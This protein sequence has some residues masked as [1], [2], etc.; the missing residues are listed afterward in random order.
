MHRVF[1]FSAGPAMLPLEVLEASAKAL[2]DFQGKGVGIAEVSHRGKE[3]DGVL[4][5]C[6]ARCRALLGV[7]DTYDVVFLQGG[8][9][10]LFTT[11]PMNFLQGSADFVVT[12]EW[13]K[14]AAEAAKPFGLANI[15]GS[16]EA[17]GFD[18]IPR[19]WKPNAGASYLHICSNNTIYGTRWSHFPD[20][21]TLICDASS[22]ICSRPMDVSRFAMIYAGAQKNLGPSGVVLAIVRKDLY[23]RIPKSVPKIFNFAAHAEAKSCLN[24]PPTFG[25]YMLLE[26]FRWLDRQGGLVAMEKRNEEKAGLIYA[27]IDQSGGYYRPTV[28]DIAN[29]SR[30]NITY[31]L[32]N[33]DLTDKFIKEAEKKGMT[34]LKGYRSVGGIRASVYNAMPIEGCQAL[35]TH[36]REFQGRNPVPA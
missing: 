19:D 8:A 15:L 32:P 4:D 13:A 18:R 9:T 36:M 28:T 14:K 10:Q 31:R 1:N 2:V 17:T 27:A 22:E 16:S 21:P 24:T 30:M 29:R 25:I 33:E 3:F 23:P 5:E 7:P 26:T 6:T 20:H 12:G 11:I 34:A 35:A